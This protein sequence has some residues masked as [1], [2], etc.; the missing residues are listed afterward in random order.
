MKLGSN[1]HLRVYEFDCEIYGWKEVA[2]LFTGSIGECGYPRVCGQYG[3]CSNGLC[4]CLASSGGTSLFQQVDDRLPDLGCS[5][6]VPL[7]C[8]ASQNQSLM[9]LKYVTYFIFNSPLSS[10]PFGMDI[11]ASSCKEA[12]TKNCSCK[13]A[14]FQHTWDGDST[15]GNCYLLTQVFS[16]LNVNG[17]KS[18]YNSTTYL[19]VHDVTTEAPNRRSKRLPVK[20]GSG[21]GALLA[22]MIFIVAILLFVQKRDDN[23]AEED[24]LDQIPGMP[25]RFTYDDLRAITNEFS[26]K[27]G[28][29]GFSSV[30]E[31]TLG[32][33]TKVAIKRLDGFG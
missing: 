7:S 23:Q 17:N 8:G 29:G 2:D 10:Y 21:L 15:G 30:F 32:D 26:K 27:L 3:I 5:E 33:G 24:Y 18:Y 13:A 25:T 9:E 22:M 19:K 31:G 12:C 14:I 28:E 1:G 11:D 6:N 16:L 20:L 4:D